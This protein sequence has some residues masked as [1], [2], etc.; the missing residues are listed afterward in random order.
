[1]TKSEKLYAKIVNN[2]KN[3]DFEELDRLLQKYGF[4]RS[5]PRSGSRH[6]T[7]RHPDLVNI[8]TIPFGGL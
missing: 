3:V 5:N 6:F 4:K 8:L 2:P 1:M 7:Y